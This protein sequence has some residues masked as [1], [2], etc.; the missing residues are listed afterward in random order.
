MTLEALIPE[1]VSA[2]EG[3]DP[4]QVAEILFEMTDSLTGATLA[5]QLALVKW[6][7]IPKAAAAEAAAAMAATGLRAWLRL[8]VPL[9]T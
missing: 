2:V 4:A 6:P 8:A 7:A 9:E 1:A 5:E 3:A